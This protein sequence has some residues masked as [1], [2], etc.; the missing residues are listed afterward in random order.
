VAGGADLPPGARGTVAH[1]RPRFSQVWLQLDAAAGPLLKR[2]RRRLDRAAGA[3]TLLTEDAAAALAEL[4]GEGEG[5]ETEPGSGSGS[6]DADAAAPGSDDEDAATASDASGAEDEEEAPASASDDGELVAPRPATRHGARRPAEDRFLNFDDMEAFLQDAERVAAEAE[7]E[8]GDG[9]DGGDGTSE[10]ESD[11]GGDRDGAAPDV[12]YADFFGDD[13]GEESDGGSESDDPAAAPSHQPTPHERRLARAAASAAAAEEDA[14]DAKPWHMAGEVGAKG[15][16]ENSALELDLDFERAAP[17][18]LPPSAEA[19]ADLESLILARVREANWDDP[20]RPPPPPAP[21]ARA[22]LELDDRRSAKGLADLYEEEYKAVT[23][24]ADGAAAD[25]LDPARA[26]ARAVARAL[27]ARLDALTH[28]RL[29]PAVGEGDAAPAPVPDAGVPAL[30]AEEAAPLAASAAP[31]RAP[32]EVWAPPRG[33]AA[34]RAAP[35]P[36]DA[37]RG[38]AGRARRARKRAGAAAKRAGAATAPT[39]GALPRGRKSEAAASAARA[40]SK[41]K[42][43]V[44]KAPAAAAMDYTKSAGVFS[45]LQRRKDAK[46]GKGDAP[47]AA[48]GPTGKALKL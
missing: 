7:G 36:A 27:F 48:V 24:G 38:D 29:A 46:A 19:T 3:E 22:P 15:R 1:P 14:M 30:A 11:G 32:E 23:C 44:S 42:G 18:P 35:V 47:A 33:A 8:E 37:E 10:S 41:K 39:P 6:D 17:P 4:L 43:G 40:A 12:K 45:A 31:A 34:S 21:P 28:A 16:P 9:G 25:G 2:A 13:A 26:S 5:E 20:P